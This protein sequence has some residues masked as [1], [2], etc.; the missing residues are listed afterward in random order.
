[1]VSMKKM[2]SLQP[3]INKLRERYNN[4][5]QKLNKEMMD[6]YKEQRINPLG[7]CLPLILQMPVFI[8]LYQV[9]WRSVE[10]KGANFLWIKDLSEPDRLLIFP[11]SLP[12]IGNELNVLPV[13]MVVI[14][15]IQQKLS[16]KSMVVS[17]SSQLAQQK[18]MMTIFPVFIGVI[19]Y[20]FASGLALYFTLFYLMS[21]FA[22]WKMS[23]MRLVSH[24]EVSS[25][26][27]V[28]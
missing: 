9:L 16:A 18:M 1:M 10:F 12:F 6:L 17:D 22:Q 25:V 26:T 23:K 28:S 19:F 27:K 24:E 20:K 4:N 13:V 11:F 15:A 7:G 21:T 5:P 8:G 14:M 3:K 2:Q